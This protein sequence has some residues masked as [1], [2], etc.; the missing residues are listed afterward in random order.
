ML[1]INDVRKAERD[2]LGSA[3]SLGCFQLKQAP[4]L[5][6]PATAAVWAV[7]SSDSS[8]KGKTSISTDHAEASAQM[9]QAA[10]HDMGISL[11]NAFDL[12][13]V[14]DHDSISTHDYMDSILNRQASSGARSTAVA[15]SAS[16]SRVSSTSSI[17]RRREAVKQQLKQT[18][19]RAT[20]M[21]MPCIAADAMLMIQ[22]YYALLRQ[23]GQGQGQGHAALDVGTH[24]VASL[25]RLTTASAR[26]HLRNDVQA[27]PDAVLAIYMLQQS[28]KDKVD[29]L[30]CA[31]MQQQGQDSCADVP[32]MSDVAV[33]LEQ[34]NLDIDLPAPALPT[35]FCQ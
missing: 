17:S 15:V 30:G 20:A 14:Y 25:L 18:I 27:M 12:A 4:S 3:L 2:S 21:P 29:Q 26:L 7:H 28:L 19:A 35:S 13:L 32:A 8:G 22:Q 6:I 11:F 24:T 1:R 16:S 9:M 5:P 34:C 31:V 33:S 23:Q 10:L